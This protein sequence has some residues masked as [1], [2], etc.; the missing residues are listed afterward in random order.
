[1][2]GRKPKKRGRYVLRIDNGHLIEVSKEIYQE[3]YRL[4]RREKYQ[5]QRDQKHGVCSIEALGA[6]NIIP[7]DSC[8]DDLEEI[9]INKINREMV[10]D[11]IMKLPKEDVDLI[12][13]L[14]Y[15]EFS[16]REIATMKRCSRR[17]IYNRRNRVL[18][19]LR[20][21]LLGISIEV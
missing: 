15:K 16:I 18:E 2:R 20:T 4:R 11:V 1:M 17:T 10:Y 8:S 21:M 3:W 14:F 12:Y 5:K 7:Y 13:L 9:I 6:D 19:K